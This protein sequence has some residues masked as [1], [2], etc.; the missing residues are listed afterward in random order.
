MKSIF[1]AQADVCEVFF[2]YF[3]ALK[4]YEYGFVLLKIKLVPAIDNAS[5][6]DLSVHKYTRN[7]LHSSAKTIFSR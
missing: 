6:S 7:S 3:C 1:S 2:L 5:N 4:S